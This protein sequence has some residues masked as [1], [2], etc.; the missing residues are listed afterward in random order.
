M[1]ERPETWRDRL[2][3]WFPERQI[4][5]RTD[6][7]VH[8]FHISTRLQCTVILVAAG[9]FGWA[10]FTSWSFVEHARVIESK[11]RDI[12]NAKLA[13][14]SLLGEMADYQNRFAATVDD[15]ENNHA[16]MLSLVEKNV[17]LQQSLKS[18]SKRLVDTESERESVRL[19]REVLKRKLNGI[20]NELRKTANK[21]YSLEGNL[22]SVENDL[23]TALAERN[24]ALF[25]STSMRREISQLETRLHALQ[26]NEEESVDRLASQAASS[27]DSYERIIESAGLK[28]NDIL[29]ANGTA[30]VAL[31]GNANDSVGQGGPFIPAEK[32][33]L[34]ASSLKGKLSNLDSQLERWDS[35]KDVIRNLPLSPPLDTYYITSKFGKRLDPINKKW[36]AHYGL[37]FGGRLKSK[38][39]APAPGKVTFAGWKS[40]YGRFIEVDHGAGIRT[41]YAHLNAI[42]VKK[43]QLVKFRDTIGL[44]GNSGRSTGAHLHY[45]TVFNGKLLNPL[46][47]IKAGRYVFQEE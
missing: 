37:D 3:R 5:I 38:I 26:Q 11:N 30:A 17:S 20:E 41:R 10:S 9:L 18:V 21:A 34:P 40:K 6:G 25:E 16:L 7:H 33:A 15:L 22:S 27:I 31:D 29:E 19:A 28:V 13:Y 35:L 47:F 42:F 14:H 24:Q 39:L 36:S 45:E 23:Q 2:R 1:D 46:K 12:T 4:H 32:D 44:L 8:F 43:G